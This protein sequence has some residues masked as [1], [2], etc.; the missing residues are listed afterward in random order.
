MISLCLKPPSPRPNITHKYKSTFAL[1]GLGFL[2]HSY[3][4]M[5]LGNW[6]I[7]GENY[8]HS[9]H[10]GGCFR[11]YKL[12]CTTLECYAPCRRPIYYCTDSLFQGMKR[13]S[14]E[15]MHLI[16][17]GSKHWFE[18]KLIRGKPYSME[19]MQ[20]ES[21]YRVTRARLLLK[22]ILCSV[23]TL[24]MAKAVIV[25]NVAYYPLWW[26]WD[27]FVTKEGDANAHQNQA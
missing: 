10:A 18:Q 1:A 17:I 22:E 8:D 9:C 11:N 24:S 12:C 16:K 25:D 2:P 4:N 3:S 7:T 14:L 27:K 19:L 15:I 21:L 5:S 20:Y 26:S 6:T 23:S 13:C